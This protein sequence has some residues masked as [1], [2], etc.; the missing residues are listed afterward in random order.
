LAKHE[1]DRQ[2]GEPSRWYQLFER[3]RL[4]GPDR[5][6]LAAYNSWRIAKGREKSCSAAS[7]SWLRRSAEWRWKQRAEAWDAYLANQVAEAEE[8]RRLEIL[9][10]GLAL[11]HE[12]VRELKDLGVLLLD[13]IRETDKRWVPDVKTVGSGPDAERVNIVRFNGS[14]IEQARGVL[15]DLAAE[16][17]ERRKNVDM[18]TG[19]NPLPAGQTILYIPDNRR[20]KKEADDDTIASG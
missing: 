7:K 9:S 10:S 4:L 14:L 2:E 6:L 13:E 19:G 16:L 15:D 17:G 3:Y 18:T 12:R 8:K 1:W 11:R 20:D 5:S